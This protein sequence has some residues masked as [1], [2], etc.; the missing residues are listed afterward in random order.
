MIQEVKE[1]PGIIA[2]YKGDTDHG[3]YQVLIDRTAV[4]IKPYLREKGAKVEIVVVE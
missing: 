1:L 4:T 3:K 2:E